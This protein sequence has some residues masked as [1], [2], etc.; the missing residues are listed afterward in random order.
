[1]KGISWQ[2]MALSL[3]IGFTLA[4]C[5][6]A[7]TPPPETTTPTLPAKTP[8]V[9]P[10]FTPGRLATITITPAPKPSPTELRPSPTPKPTP[11]PIKAMQ[12]VTITI[13][14]DNNPYAPGLKTAWGFSCLVEKGEEVVLFDTGGDAYI[15]LGNM[16]LL[17]IDPSRINAVVLSHIHGDHTGGLGGVLA[18]NSRVTVFLPRSFPESFK[19]RLRSQVKVVEIGD[20]GEIMPGIYTTGEMGTSIREQGL[21]VD[22][23]KGAVLITGCAH[24]GIVKM[25]EKAK[26]LRGEIY[27]VMGGFHLGGVSEAEIARIVSAFRR[28]DVKKVAPCHC[29]GDRARQAFKREYG[30]DCILAGVGSRLSF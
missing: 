19:T 10:T 16:Q 1:M 25:V 23:P 2:V 20:P 21:V 12:G 14:Y 18:L 6:K 24:P 8:T 30:A 17:G 22:T 7:Y 3:S 4:G 5:M 9:T 13:L 29:S 26:Q 28:L 15:L 27:L 11:T